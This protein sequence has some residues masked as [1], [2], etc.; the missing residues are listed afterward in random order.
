MSA[1]QGHETPLR[2][3]SSIFFQSHR[4]RRLIIVSYWVVILLATPLWWHTTSIER[5]SLPTAQVQYQ[6]KTVL[7]FPITIRLDPSLVQDD[8]SI[9]GKLQQLFNTHS[10]KGGQWRGLS[11]HVE[12]GSEAGTFS[13]TS[14]A[15]FVSHESSRLPEHAWDI[16][17][18]L[19]AFS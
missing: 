7:S 4:V 12:V 9:T 17:R 3:P 15:K 8:P 2:D 5:L 10:S 11:I 18:H 13:L 19:G 16:F 14:A 6:A 1:S